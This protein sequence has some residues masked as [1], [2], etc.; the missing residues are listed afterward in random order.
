MEIP[1]G[2]SR[3]INMA[4]VFRRMNFRTLLFLSVL[5]L[6][7]TLT[8][9]E[10]LYER[11]SQHEGVIVAS[12]KGFPLDSVSRIEVIV[13]EA[14]TDE[15]WAWM[16]QEFRI[17]DLMPDQQS[18]LRE[19]SDVVLFARRSRANPGAAVPM[20]GDNIDV[21][22]SCYMGISYLRRAVYIFCADSEEQSDAIVTLLVKKIMHM[23]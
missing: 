5:L 1:V 21:S 11:Y 22:A 8:A 15:G 13:V 20:S 16:R 4:K 18:E 7:F 17:A 2:M 14:T 19:G 10:E 12:V 9:Q 23:R 3:F 6:P